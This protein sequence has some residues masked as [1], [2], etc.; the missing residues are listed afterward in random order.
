MHPPNQLITSPV[1]HLRSRSGQRRRGRRLRRPRRWGC[2]VGTP[3]C[4]PAGWCPCSAARSSC[5]R[6]Q[7]GMGSR[8][9]PPGPPE[10]SLHAPG[11]A[12]KCGCVVAGWVCRCRSLRTRN[13]GSVQGGQ[14]RMRAQQLSSAGWRPRTGGHQD[15]G[16]DAVGQPLADVGLPIGLHHHWDGAR[17]LDVCRHAGKQGVVGGRAGGSGELLPN[18]ARTACNTLQRLQCS[19]VRCPGCC[20]TVHAGK[21][22]GAP[23]AAAASHEHCASELVN[24]VLVP[25]LLPPL[26]ETLSAGY[27]VPWVSGSVGMIGNKDSTVAARVRRRGCLRFAPCHHMQGTGAP[28]AVQDELMLT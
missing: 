5:R 6:C 25:E 28:A 13:S 12:A 15:V 20:R 24:W 9:G 21:G 19:E 8:T 14:E 7:T 27:Q 22:G 3:Q 10:C 23:R 18:A 4:R 1:T 11:R 16:G 2:L 17:G 26:P